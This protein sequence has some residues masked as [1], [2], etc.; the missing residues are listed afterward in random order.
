MPACKSPPE[1]AAGGLL[2]AHCSRSSQARA[3]SISEEQRRRLQLALAL[4]RGFAGRGRT[5]AISR[6]VQFPL[7]H[8]DAMPALFLFASPCG[9]EP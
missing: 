9:I 2:A 5:P 1:Q 4:H 6:N 7:V 8:A 3:S